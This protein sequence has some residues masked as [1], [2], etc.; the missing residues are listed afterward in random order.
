MDQDWQPDAAKKS[1]I[2]WVP[3]YEALSYAWGDPEVRTPIYMNGRMVL[4][5]QNLY[6]ALRT[7]RKADKDQVLWVDAL[8]INQDDIQERSEQVER[9]EAI[10]QR[11]KETIMWLGDADKSSG[12]AME[13]LEK[14]GG[15][16]EQLDSIEWPE[17]L[18]WNGPRYDLCYGVGKRPEEF[19]MKMGLKHLESFGLME[20]IDL[21]ESDW[22]ALE[23]ILTKR[24]Y[25]TRLWVVQEVANS[26]KATIRCGSKS[27]SLDTLWYL[28]C[29]RS[30]GETE[31]DLPAKELIDNSLILDNQFKNLIKHPYA[32]VQQRRLSRH[33][34]R[35]LGMEDGNSSLLQILETFR[36]FQCTN[37]VDR[38]YALLGLPALDR[39][40]PLLKPDYRKSAS[41][42]YCETVRAIIQHTADLTVL[43][44]P[45]E[46]FDGVLKYNLPSWVPDW[47]SETDNRSDIFEVLRSNSGGELAASGETLPEGPEF[48]FEIG[49]SGQARKKK[50]PWRKGPAF[51][52]IVGGDRGY[53]SNPD[54]LGLTRRPETQKKPQPNFRRI[55]FGGFILDNPQL[56]GGE[57]PA[58][59]FDDESWKDVIIGWEKMLKAFRVFA[60]V[61]NQVREINPGLRHPKLSEFINLLLRGIVFTHDKIESTEDL[62]DVYV[63]HYLLWTNRISARE[64]RTPIFPPLLSILEHRLKKPSVDIS[65]L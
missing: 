42:V 62:D 8:C 40:M 54:H 18:S 45:K 31:S 15:S 51:K 24:P 43:C 63:E 44:L 37:P 64:A 50:R 46:N 28:P 53:H 23:N 21:K 27:M 22:E 32:L 41:E 35:S 38:I 56:M 3:E 2:Y 16:A 57:I 33:W 34:S 12:K 17:S 55:E 14:L 26:Q 30:R 60:R 20:L 13:L 39:D 6:S 19:L 4:V 65:S 49:S 7:L 61:E 36:G 58:S 29:I 5:T 52:M 59:S 10:Y 9:I 47:I 25:W 11:A 1:K 48:N